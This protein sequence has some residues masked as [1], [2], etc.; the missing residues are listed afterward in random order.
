MAGLRGSRTGAVVRE[1][2][3]EG[4]YEGYA[5]AVLEVSGDDE[6]DVF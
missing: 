3:W 1:A 6:G 2:V 4:M 5:G